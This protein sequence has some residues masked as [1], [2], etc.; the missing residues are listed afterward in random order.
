MGT[1]TIPHRSLF[2][3]IVIAV[4]ITLCVSWLSG[5][6][7]SDAIDTWYTGLNRPWFAPPNWIFGPVWTA[8]YI[9]MGIGAGLVWNAGI[10]HL[11]V[12]RALWLYATQLILNAAWSLIFFGMQEMAWALAEMLLLWRAI[13]ATVIAFAMVRRASAWLLLPYSVW[14]SFAMV[15]NAAYV[16][17]N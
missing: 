8:L 11:Q 13:I 12:R 14:V 3:R 1:F 17:L 16:Y 6:A 15:L 2:P 10:E 4:V 7:T 9:M 5:W